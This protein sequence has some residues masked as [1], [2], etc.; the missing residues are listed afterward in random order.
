[1]DFTPAARSCFLGSFTCCAD[2]DLATSWASRQQISSSPSRTD[3]A[4]QYTGTWG[5]PPRG[6]AAGV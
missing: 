3:P 1:M 4:S 6:K 5:F 2:L